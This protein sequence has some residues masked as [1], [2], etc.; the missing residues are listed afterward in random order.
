MAALFVAGGGA[1]A[2]WA[3]AGPA[4]CRAS[5]MATVASSGLRMVG[6]T[7][8]S[9]PT[10]VLVLQDGSRE[11]FLIVKKAERYFITEVF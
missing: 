11:T 2:V 9:P 8:G 6:E 1:A 4:A 5:V 7:P 3:S 10:A